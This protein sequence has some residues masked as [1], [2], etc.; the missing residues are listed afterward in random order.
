MAE[1]QPFTEPA[2]P[3]E[4]APLIGLKVE[5][6]QR[7]CRLGL[8]PTL[9][10][11]RPYRIAAS[12]ANFL[13]GI[14]TNG[15]HNLTESTGRKGGSVGTHHGDTGT[16][17]TRR[18][19][20]SLGRFVAVNGHRDTGCPSVPGKAGRTGTGS[21]PGKTAGIGPR[22]LRGRSVR[23]RETPGQAAR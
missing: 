8:I 19:R 11:G 10:I 17:R 4:L 9:P 13:A 6:V 14:E 7:K 22:R 12:V 23:S 18:P 2:S 5:T 1:P 3:K 16:G 20:N 15:K 21:K